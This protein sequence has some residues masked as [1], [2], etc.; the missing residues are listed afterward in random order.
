MQL[1]IAAWE[2]G[3]QSCGVR[4][5]AWKSRSKSFGVEVAGRSCGGGIE[6][7]KAQVVGWAGG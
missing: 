2:L 6:E 5:T 3:R 1:A 4:V 7:W